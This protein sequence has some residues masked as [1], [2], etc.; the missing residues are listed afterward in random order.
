[1]GFMDRAGAM[2]TAAEMM[3]LIR[4][5]IT[6]IDNIQSVNRELQEY[7]KEHTQEFPLKLYEIT[8]KMD[9]AVSSL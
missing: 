8:Q 6:A 4:E 5:F 7:V 9:R 1:M 2:K 3:R